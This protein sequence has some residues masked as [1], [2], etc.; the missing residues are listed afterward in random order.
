MARERADE[1][2]ASTRLGGLNLL[3]L[4]AAVTIVA[5]LGGL[6][7]TGIGTIWSARVSADQ[8]AQSREQ[9]EEKQREQ[10][11]RVSFW[12]DVGPKGESRLHVMNRSPDPISNLHIVFLVVEDPPGHVAFQVILPAL[13]PCSALTIEGKSLKYVENDPE[14]DPEDENSYWLPLLEADADDMDLGDFE[15][16]VGFLNASVGFQ[17]RNGA[18]WARVNGEL[19][20]GDVSIDRTPARDGRVLG[21]PQ[22]QLVDNCGDDGGS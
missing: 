12:E 2:E 18:Y 6:I 3:T 1:P 5:S 20:R 14:D 7:T 21:E 10:A 8:L 15:D 17:D 19:T 9:A 22:V 13:T 11:A 4:G 16:S